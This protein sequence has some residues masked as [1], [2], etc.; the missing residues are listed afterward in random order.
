MKKRFALLLAL[1]TLLSV[2]SGCFNK[3]NEG[4]TEEDPV[5]D[6]LAD[7]KLPQPTP[8]PTPT[9]APEVTVTPRPID[10]PVITAAP[11][12]TP[13]T[14]DPIDKPKKTF[15]YSAYDNQ[16]LGVIFNYPG[17]WE[18][19]NQGDSDT[20]TFVEPMSE[21]MDNFQ[22]FLE[23]TVLHQATNQSRE[24]AI[25]MLNML[26]TSLRDQFPG[27]EMSSL[28]DNNRMLGEYGYYYNYRI[29]AVGDGFAIRGRIFAV[30]VNRMLILADLRVPARYN[31]DYMDIFRELRTT[32][33]MP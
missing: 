24:D 14:L 16:S 20:V 18:I 27:I 30:A 31:A 15:K 5:V 17:T 8:T 1:I 6:T 21:M 7:E 22:A 2:L 29:P 26:R 19:R 10:I 3:N 32:A 4:G 9:H 12:T 23:V 25:D 13:D 28:G 11:S 33:K